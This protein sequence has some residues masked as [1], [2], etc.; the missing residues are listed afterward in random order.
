MK[1]LD[2]VEMSYCADYV[3]IDL[4]CSVEHVFLLETGPALWARN[5]ADCVAYCAAVAVACY[6]IQN[7]LA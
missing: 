5:V 1:S 2:D 4:G 6:C 7:Y 3:V